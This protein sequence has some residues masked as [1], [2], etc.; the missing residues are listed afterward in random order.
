MAGRPWLGSYPEGIPPSLEPYPEVGLFSLLEGSAGGF[1]RNTALA[2]F[3]KHITYAE[4]LA[5]AERCSA[6]LAALGVRQGDRVGFVLPNCPQYVIAYYAAV[7]LG[8]IV[9]GNNPLYTTDELARQLKDADA[10]VVVVLDQLYEKVAAVREEA[11]V[12]EVVVTKLT[13]YMPFPLNLLAP[14]RFRRDAR[15]KGKP[16]PPVPREASVRWWRRVM[17][18]AGDTPPPANVDPRADPAGFI[19]TGGTTGVSKGAML[20]HY[21][22]IANAIQSA[23]WCD[24]REGRETIMC[25]LPFFHSYGMTTQLNVGML[26]AAK[27]VLVPRFELH[28]VLKAIQ[29]EG[30]TLFPGVPKLYQSINDADES[31]GFDLSSIRACVSGAGALPAVVA[32]K[33][34]GLTGATVVEGYGL[35]EASPVTHA[36]PL[37]GRARAGSIGLPLPDTD[38]RLVAVAEPDREVGPGEEGELVIKG[39]QVM[40]GYWNRPDESAMTVR[41][42]WLHTGDVAVMEED[43]FFRIVDRIKDMVKISGFNVYPTEVEEVLYRH[44]KVLKCC[45]A[46]VPDAKGGE[47]LKAYVVLRS[48]ETATA[49]EITDHAR[50]HLA[51]YRVPKLIEFRESLPETMIGKVL[52]RVLLEEERQKAGAATAR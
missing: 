47:V 24:V 35:T 31:R 41:N 21:N 2:F 33:F 16:W 42:G 34:R 28:M 43:G 8:A 45:V 5:E 40:L 27:L 44:P 48:G 25:V 14:L 13:D 49:A 4:L 29:K 22:M 1:P 32:E 23:V 15:S 37:D 3:G 39:P 51:G 19:Y 18:N 52:R 11:G 6:V 9:V 36:N 46:G 26:R 20:S 30:P 50:R 17:R 10:R 12:R 38:C 7:R